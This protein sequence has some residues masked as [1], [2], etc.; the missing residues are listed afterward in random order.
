[1]PQPRPQ[2]DRNRTVYALPAGAH[3]TLT[4]AG[5]HTTLT[6]ADAHTTLTRAD[7]SSR[8][9]S[10]GRETTPPHQRR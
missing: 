4:R 9:N 3:T 6:R 8:S 2:Q 5:A 1:L 10:L 7:A